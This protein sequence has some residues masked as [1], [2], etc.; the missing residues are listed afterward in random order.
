MKPF[1]VVWLKTETL[2][3]ELDTLKDIDKI[4][5]FING[6]P[7]STTINKVVGAVR[8]FKWNGKEYVPYIHKWV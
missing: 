4:E 2:E 5:D 1:K 6:E 8:L 7:E 3:A